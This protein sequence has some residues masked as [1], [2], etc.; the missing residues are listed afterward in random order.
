MSRRLA[1][2]LTGSI[3]YVLPI[4]VLIAAYLG[5]RVFLA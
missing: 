1:L 4:V 3:S 2:A 5:W